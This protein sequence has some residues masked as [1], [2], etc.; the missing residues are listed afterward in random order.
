MKSNLRDNTDVNKSFSFSRFFVLFLV[1]EIIQA[2]QDSVYEDYKYA[3]NSD[4][5]RKK[6]KEDNHPLYILVNANRMNANA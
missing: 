1:A 6:N 3:N 4:T 5:S 2:V